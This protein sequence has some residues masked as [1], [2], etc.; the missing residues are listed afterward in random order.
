[1]AEAGGGA[2]ESK[3]EKQPLEIG[4][5]FDSD[6][7]LPITG[8]QRLDTLT[9]DMGT[10]IEDVAND[11]KDQFNKVITFINPLNMVDAGA[12]NRADLR[13]QYSEEG[14]EYCVEINMPDS[15]INADKPSN[16]YVTSKYTFWNFLPL[17]L[18]EQF[19]RVANF[20]FL[21]IT[22]LMLIPGV[23]PI[24]PATTIAPLIVILAVSAV[25]AGLEDRQRALEDEK[26]NHMKLKRLDPDNVEMVDVLSQDLRV[27]DLILVEEGQEFPA[28]LILLAS[29]REVGTAF[30]DTANLDGETSL[31]LRSCV[32]RK[33]WNVPHPEVL[34]IIRGRINCE[35]PNPAIDSFQGNFDT[36][37][38]NK[39]TM[40]QEQLLLR[41]AVLRNTKWVA[42]AVVYVG[43]DT[44]LSLNLEGAS[45]KF[46]RVEILLNRCV[47][48]IFGLQTIVCLIYSGLARG[49]DEEFAQAPYYFHL[50]DSYRDPVW[51]YIYDMFTWFILCSYLIP[52]NLYVLCEFAKY[53]MKF[54]IEW[55]ENMVDW[56][57]PKSP[58]GPRVNVS[59]VVEELGQI[60]YILSDKTGTLTENIM[61]LK[62]MSAS[63]IMLD[64]PDEDAGI[65]IQSERIRRV[66]REG[67]GV[68]PSES[69]KAS[70][71]DTTGEDYYG[72]EKELILLAMAVCSTATCGK[73][74][75]EYV[76]ESPDEVALAKAARA[77]GIEMTERGLGRCVISKAPREQWVGEYQ[78][79]AQLDFTSS[80]RRMDT[81]VRAPDGSIMLFCKGADSVMFDRTDVGS[82]PLEAETDRSTRHGRDLNA[83][84]THLSWFSQRGFR[85]LVVSYSTIDEGMLSKWLVKWREAKAAVYDRSK[86]EEEAFTELEQQTVIVGCTA[87]EDKL[88]EG[89]EETL[90]ALRDAGIQI[91]MLTG[92]KQETAINIGY[93]T[94]LMRLNHTLLAQVNFSGKNASAENSNNR[95]DLMRGLLD[96]IEKT[97][98][99]DSGEGAKGADIEAALVIDGNSTSICL[100]NE[101]EK[102][103]LCRLM[104]VCKTAIC[105]RMTPKQKAAMVRLLKNDFQRVSL[106]VGD[107]ANDVSMIR[108]ANVG[109][110][111]LGKE[112]LQ[113]VN[114]ADFA[115][116]QFK[117]LRRLILVHG[118]TAYIRVTSVMTAAFFA[119]LAFNIPIVM[120]GFYS[121]FSGQ[122]IFASTIMGSY[123][124]VFTFL[125]QVHYVFFE[126][127]VSQE[128]LL[129]YPE[130]YKRLSENGGLF[131]SW[132]FLKIF[133]LALWHAGLCFYVIVWSLESQAIQFGGHELNLF[134]LQMIWASATIIG[135]IVHT[136]L[137]YSL[138]TP[139]GALC[140]VL[141]IFL[142]CLLL[143]LTPIIW[144]NE[145]IMDDIAC[146]SLFHPGPLLTVLFI[147][148]GSVFPVFAYQVLDRFWF[149]KPHH[150]VEELN[151]SGKPVT[152]SFRRPRL[153]STDKG[154]DGEDFA[155]QLEAFDKIAA[156]R[157][158][159]DRAG[160]GSRNV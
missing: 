58:K 68:I 91:A 76:G 13:R 88:Q 123:N 141:D 29:S 106:A 66:S 78:V 125:V 153:S 25:R 67:R 93:N 89:V 139:L 1:M 3:E 33:E 124:L 117:H 42:G 77:N 72:K 115:L 20:Y 103:L 116:A 64:V 54:F 52:M 31:K 24:S 127:D 17:N 23:A 99:A 74:P 111:I 151:F 51:A 32:G 14:V 157:A 133:F 16:K 118:R 148:V 136:M 101:A 119:N 82:G 61:S 60:Q 113:A 75:G 128:T 48:I 73:T 114:S 44:K 63:G 84:R 12:L 155:K 26:I 53:S 56:R 120:Y 104:S 10:F 137:Q 144:P 146:A 142:Y 2:G 7:S 149:T 38:G 112:G 105:N 138:F 47:M 57:D 62:G 95:Q 126:R 140:I 43:R 18:L 109:V 152:N 83:L 135:V 27:G 92:D 94:G 46:S 96:K 81:L 35:Q 154:D 37:Y 15:S 79:L 134:S 147:V 21:V 150:I 34:A 158:S 4:S 45:F 132:T 160:S 131:N 87:V 39:V 108:E 145:M 121:G 59:T 65:L 159:G 90:V 85:T 129:Q 71:T 97:C 100:S 8:R 50:D 5:S 143:Y 98:G 102:Q 22:V 55:D 40:S 30:I 86:R 41:G 6:R 130:A 11:V 110:G 69:P 156:A 107:G 49:V 9:A 80:R 122:T 19:M 36:G 70:V 28:D